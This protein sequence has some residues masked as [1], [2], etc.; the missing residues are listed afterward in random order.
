[1]N[2]IE[3]AWLWL[4]GGVVLLIAEVIAPG[5]FLM[6]IGGAAIATGLISAIVPLGLPLQL[7][8]FAILAVASARIGGRRAYAR[9]YDYSPDPYLNDRAGRLLGKVVVVVEAVDSDGGRVRV[10]DSQWSA[11]GGPAAIGE[12]VRV[13]D[14]EG[15]CLKV[16]PEH[17]LPP[18]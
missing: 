13:V 2:G 11:R 14:I 12:R 16:E 7:A 5:F 17:K 10:G 8:L 18:P 4:I 3:P 1:M 9:R 15:N 6:F